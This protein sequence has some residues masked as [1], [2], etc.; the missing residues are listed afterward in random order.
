MKTKTCTKCGEVKA[1]SAF[2]RNGPHV[3]NLCFVC[4][5]LRL[6]DL[7]ESE[8]SRAD[9][10]A[11]KRNKSTYGKADLAECSDRYVASSLKIPLADCP[12][13]LIAL[14]REQLQLHRLAKQLNQVIKD[15]Q[16]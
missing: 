14:K 9:A 16:K 7:A 4:A 6:S 2:R 11:T 3:S 5:P 15:A 8:Q 10:R 13:E 12:S 1:A